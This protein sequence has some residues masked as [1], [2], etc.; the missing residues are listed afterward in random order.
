MNN[1]LGDHLL[2]THIQCALDGRWEDALIVDRQ[3][4]LPAS[5]KFYAWIGEKTNFALEV[6]FCLPHRRVMFVGIRYMHR[7]PDELY[8]IVSSVLLMME[9]CQTSGNAI[10]PTQ[11]FENALHLGL[12]SGEPCFLVPLC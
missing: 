2:P 3:R 9:Q 5:E 1:I 11:F 12:F 10:R 6:L 8:E 4:L 7:R